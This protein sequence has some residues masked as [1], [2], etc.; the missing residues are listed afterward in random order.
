MQLDTGAERRRVFGSMLGVRL[1]GGVL[2]PLQLLLRH[3]ELI[4]AMATRDILVSYA[5]QM[6]GGLWV[7]VHPLFLVSLLAVI[8]NFLFGSKFGGTAA[9]PLDY[10]VYILSGL[11]PWQTFALVLGRSSLDVVGQAN[12]VKQVVFP[13]EVLPI[14]GVM[15]SLVTLVVGLVFV[16]AYVLL[17]TG[18]LPWTYFL[19]GG[20]FILQ[21]AWMCG[22]A[23]LLSALGVYFR[24]LKDVM[25]LLVVA[26]VY[27][28]PVIYPPGAMPRL[29]RPVIYLNPFSYLVWCYQ[30]VLYFGRFENLWAWPIC[31]FLSL[32][33]FYA[34]FYLFQKLKPFFGNVL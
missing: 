24:D 11:L 23:L 3:R 15:T 13:L 34:G 31:I 20:L 17:T 8:F 4:W 18:K 26:G 10:T 27:I 1:L 33:S 12:L 21:M 6:L 16:L 5:G 25:G 22:A 7:I 19:L 32:G 30:D 29:I 28:L 2:W 9:L 14:K